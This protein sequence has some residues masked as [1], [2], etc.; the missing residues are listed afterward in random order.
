MSE[1]LRRGFTRRDCFGRA[2]KK[3]DFGGFSFV[4]NLKWRNL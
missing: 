1:F 3:G 4:L 2:G